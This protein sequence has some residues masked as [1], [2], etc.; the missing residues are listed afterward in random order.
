[1][2]KSLVLIALAAG[3]PIY[4]LWRLE[5]AHNRLKERLAEFLLIE[6][7]VKRASQDREAFDH[8]PGMFLD[9]LRCA[10]ADLDDAREELCLEAGLEI[11]L[12]AYEVDENPY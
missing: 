7:S 9:V 4:L 12:T 11:R 10:E 8:D 3:L 1:M 2:L 5:N 6:G